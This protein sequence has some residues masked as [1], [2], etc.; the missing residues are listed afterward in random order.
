M[1]QTIAVSPLK[2]LAKL[3]FECRDRLVLLR[4]DGQIPCFLRVGIVI[5]KLATDDVATA[6]LLPHNKTITTRPQ[7]PSH[8]AVPESRVLTER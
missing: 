2:T 6:D 1:L 5:V 3:S 7:S 8:E 4:I